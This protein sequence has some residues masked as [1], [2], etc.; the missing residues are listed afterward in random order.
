MW[1]NFRILGGKSGGND[2]GKLL[3]EEISGGRGLDC[4]RSYIGNTF[5]LNSSHSNMAEMEDRL[6]LNFYGRDPASRPQ[7]FDVRKDC[8]LARL[9]YA[10]NVQ[11]V[12][13]IPPKRTSQTWTK[14]YDRRAMDAHLPGAWA[15]KPTLHF[16]A[17]TLDGGDWIMHAGLE[18]DTDYTQSD[19]ESIMIAKGRKIEDCYLETACDLLDVACSDHV[20]SEEVCLDF[21]G[22]CA[23]ADAKRLLGERQVRFLAHTGSEWLK[24]R[25][26][27]KPNGKDQHFSK[28]GDIRRDEDDPRSDAS[29]LCLNRDRRMFVPHVGIVE[30][31][32][33]ASKK[34]PPFP[35]QE[36]PP[37]APEHFSKS[38]N[39]T[40][41]SRVA[42]GYLESIAGH[43]AACREASS[44]ADNM[45]ACGPQKAYKISLPIDELLRLLALDTADNLA[46][47]Q[48]C[49][50]MSCGWFDLESASCSTNKVDDFNPALEPQFRHFD[51][52][53]E[54]RKVLCVQRPILASLIDGLQLMEG[55]EPEVLEANS[56]ASS[57]HEMLVRLSDN[58]LDRQKRAAIRKEEL[59]R[60]LTSVVARMK[61]AFFEFYERE[62]GRN[63]VNCW[64]KDDVRNRDAG[65]RRT[66]RRRQNRRGGGGDR[67]EE[68]EED[69]TT[70]TVE[71]V[72]Q[73][74]EDK[75]RLH[76]AGSYRNTLFGLLERD[77]ARLT[78]KMTWY[79]FHG[80]HYDHPLISASYLVHMRERKM[81]V[82]MRRNGNA[83]NEI[84]FGDNV[85]A[86]LAHLLAAHTSLSRFQQMTAVP[87]SK[88]A[89]NFDWLGDDLSAFDWKEL[90]EDP[91]L[92]RSRLTGETPSVE[93]IAA[94]RKLFS[95]LGCP[96]LKSYFLKYLNQDILM[97]AL[98]FKELS[99][100]FRKIFD[101]CLTQVGK[102][103][104]ASLSS[105][106]SQ[107]YL[108]KNK[109]S[110]MYSPTDCLL[111]AILKRGFRG[112]IN[113]IFAT[114]GGRDTDMAASVELFREV[115]R[116]KAAG[117]PGDPIDGDPDDGP[118]DK[119]ETPRGTPRPT[120]DST[121]E[122]I[123]AY[124]RGNNPHLVPDSQS[125]NFL[126]YRDCCALYPTS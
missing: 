27:A 99:K 45:P 86:D 54:P 66:R 105:Y 31:A 6:L 59:L 35:K 22:T 122:E 103:T 4:Y 83:V 89:F 79:S 49:C 32:L 111:F 11:I 26:M 30:E 92:W 28:L 124:L 84:T 109:Y 25:K 113:Q 95:D 72:F 96:D 94:A 71:D 104:I 90:P 7:F 76:L 87:A 57:S 37:G 93:K 38:K 10:T 15:D 36:P 46:A 19:S 14:L 48:T 65:R 117:R 69:E 75:R 8:D 97:T 21:A 118:E 50:E 55:A 29:V 13:A 42:D 101:V 115:E 116:W 98:G 53:L 114:T 110:A 102:R 39:K 56:D 12:L 20:H 51:E 2:L 123:E 34:K 5:N 43:C 78:K 58:M 16:F 23:S 47:V 73:M 44:Y 112:A 120:L 33:Q 70:H 52:A 108:Y 77:L 68:E 67:E 125:S 100:T 107:F 85:V 41:R 80:A 18:E 9:E 121:D 74:A 24:K 17:V 62:D 40:K 126:E 1:K 64:W 91:K 61:D 119:R 60:P 81:R 63:G 106:A 88:M 3:M 82:G